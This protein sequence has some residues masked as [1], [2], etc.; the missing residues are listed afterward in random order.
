MLPSRKYRKNVANTTQV[1]KQESKNS[2]PTKTKNAKKIHIND[3]EKNVNVSKSETVHNNVGN[4]SVNEVIKKEDCNNDTK[5]S[6][7]EPN[8]NKCSNNQKKQQNKKKN[9]GQIPIV[10]ENPISCV[11]SVANAGSWDSYYKML[12]FLLF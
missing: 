1:L 6:H 3:N 10:P 11:E 7:K 4:D 12:Y 8:K 9:Q 5:T 2:K